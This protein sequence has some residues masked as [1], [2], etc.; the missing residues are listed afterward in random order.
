MTRTCAICD[1]QMENYW[2]RKGLEFLRC[3]N[4]GYVGLDLERWRSPYEYRDYYSDFSFQNIDPERSFIK[5]RVAQIK[6]F[7]ETGRCAELGAGFG[8]TA[9]ALARAGFQVDAVE[10]SSMAIDHLSQNYVEVR[11]HSASVVGYL[12][13]CD[14]ESYDLAVLYHVLEHLPRPN[15]T[16]VGLSRVVSKGGLLVIEVPNFGGNHAR[17]MRDRWWYVLPHHVSYFTD[18]TLRKLL[19]PLGFQLL[20]VEGKYH[21]SYPQNVWWKDALKNAL[22][23]LGFSDVI[24]TY[25]RRL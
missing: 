17:L 23:R 6:H 10:E 15:E 18:Q 13:A 19:E 11:W 2:R 16:C 22:S 4:C 1:E 5:H 12:D 21:F 25:W 8:E 14:D 3:P 7:Q 24:C 9:I 20:R